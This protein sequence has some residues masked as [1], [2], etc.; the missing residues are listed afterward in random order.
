MKNLIVIVLVILFL[1]GC[2]TF[3]TTHI[4]ACDKEL[5]N[6]DLMQLSNKIFRVWIAGQKWVSKDGVAHFIKINPDPKG[7]P[8][9]AELQGRINQY[10]RIG[11]DR[12]V[13]KIRGGWYYMTY[14]TVLRRVTCN[15]LLSAPTP[16]P[17]LKKKDA[18]TGSVQS[19]IATEPSGRANKEGIRWR[20]GVQY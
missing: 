11:I 12:V 17:K 18:S 15:V 13:F 1:G 2:A 4:S 14:D 3:P 7:V 10:G 5:A 16:P 19:M 8:G 20:G 9:M 6:V